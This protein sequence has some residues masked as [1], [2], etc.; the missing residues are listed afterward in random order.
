MKFLVTGSIRSDRGPRL[1]VSL[2]LV[3]FFLFFLAYWLR[4]FD[5][6]GFW[7]GRMIES[8]R[9]IGAEEG[10][11]AIL[12]LEDLHVDL[13]SHSVLL[14]FLVSLLFQLPTSLF[15]KKFLTWASFLS[16]F[17]YILGRAG[18]VLSPAFAYLAFGSSLT[19]M[20][21]YLVLFLIAFRYLLGS[22]AR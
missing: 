21:V 1:I 5:A 6:M 17:A 7:P 8:V 4:E 20:I 14:L 19:S 10:R 3:G 13:L 16:C 11:S 15:W 12:M 2:T 22:D 18:I 9:G